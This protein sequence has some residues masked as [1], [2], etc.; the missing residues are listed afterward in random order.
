MFRQTELVQRNRLTRGENTHHDVFNAAGGG[1]GRHPQFNVQRAEFFELDL[2]VLRLA[3]LRDIKITH[4]FQARHQCIA[5]T[6]G[7][8]NVRRERAILAEADLGFGFARIRLDVYVRRTLLIGI[9]DDFV[10]QLYQFVVAGS[11]SD[12]V[13]GLSTLAVFVETAEKVVDVAGVFKARRAAKHLLE[14]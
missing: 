11:R 1:D 8:L 10:D 4:D 7:H 6:R 9:N 14:C 13:A 3:A 5:V 12:I 2:A